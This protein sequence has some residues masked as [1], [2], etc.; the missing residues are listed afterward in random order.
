MDHML[1]GPAPQ[2][3]QTNES[4]SIGNARP[5][6]CAVCECRLRGNSG[7]LI[8]DPSDMGAS[9]QSWLLCNACFTAVSQ[10]LLVHSPRSAYRV[11]IA[12]G[13]VATNRGPSFRREEL[14]ERLFAYLLPVTI[15]AV[16]FIHIVVF[17]LIAIIH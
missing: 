10:Q 4:R 9:R 17:F 15:T 16:V 2:A 13:V 5:G 11:R 3:H 6:Y 7:R 14:N 1:S 12:M 8:E